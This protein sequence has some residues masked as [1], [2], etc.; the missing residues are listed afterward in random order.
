MKKTIITR[1]FQISRPEFGK[2]IL[3][4]LQKNKVLFLLGNKDSGKDQLLRNDLIPAWTDNTNSEKNICINL[5][6]QGEERDTYESFRK[7]IAG[8]LGSD[9][10]NSPSI[11]LE[12]ENELL[13]QIWEHAYSSDLLIDFLRKKSNFTSPKVLI[14]FDLGKC[15]PGFQIS[16]LLWHLGQSL[17]NVFV[18]F[19]TESIQE[20]QLSGCFGHVMSDISHLSFKLPSLKPYELGKAFAEFTGREVNEAE[21]HDLLETIISSIHDSSLIQKQVSA[22]IHSTSTSANKAKIKTLPIEPEEN[23][24]GFTFRLL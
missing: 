21:I 15:E 1:D 16:K 24:D 19:L 13:E 5:Y 18:L 2:K 8:L 4:L 11:D 9:A 14:I 7:L 23:D 12:I 3:A 20:P 17:A 22:Y 6:G 10:D